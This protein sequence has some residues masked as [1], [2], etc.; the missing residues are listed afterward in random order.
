VDE[1]TPLESVIP[2]GVHSKLTLQV[3]ALL[4]EAHALSL[5]VDAACY[6]K[7]RLYN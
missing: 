3:E 2:Q 6:D 1:D 7:I 4:K 5:A